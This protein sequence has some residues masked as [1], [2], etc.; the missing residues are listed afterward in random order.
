MLCANKCFRL[1]ILNIMR[2]QVQRLYAL[3]RDIVLVRTLMLGNCTRTSA[4][5]CARVCA[6]PPC[7]RTRGYV[8]PRTTKIISSPNPSWVERKK[9]LQFFKARGLCI[10]SMLLPNRMGWR[11]SLLESYPPPKHHAKH[12]NSCQTCGTPSEILNLIPVLVPGV[13]G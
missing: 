4:C 9:G 12:P 6:F 2:C 1:Y 13:Y 8:K 11:C 10:R 3:S 5:T 7:Y